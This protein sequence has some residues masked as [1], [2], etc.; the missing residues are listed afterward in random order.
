LTARADIVDRGHTRTI[1]TATGLGIDLDL[2]DLRAVGEKLATG[3]VW[4]E[5]AGERPA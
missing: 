1:S 4:S 3:S 5:D 2:A